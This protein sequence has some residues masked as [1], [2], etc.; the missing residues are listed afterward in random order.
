MDRLDSDDRRQCN[1]RRLHF[2][3]AKAIQAAQRNKI[4]DVQQ[5]LDDL[6]PII[7]IQFKR[8]Q[9]KR[10]IGSCFRKKHDEQQ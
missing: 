10:M 2:A 9:I 8:I 7:Q 1:D 5:Q 3:G 6:L 4:P